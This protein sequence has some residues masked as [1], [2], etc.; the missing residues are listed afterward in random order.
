MKHRMNQTNK[1]MNKQTKYKD[2]V[3]AKHTHAHTRKR[4]V[5]SLEFYALFFRFLVLSANKNC[6]YR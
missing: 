5:L 3:A 4:K 1:Q 6:S 2:Q